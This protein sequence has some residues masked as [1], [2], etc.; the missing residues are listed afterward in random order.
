M[1]TSTVVADL[2]SGSNS[3]LSNITTISNAPQSVNNADQVQRD[4]PSQAVLQRMKEME[5]LVQDLK[6]KLQEKEEETNKKNA[7]IKKL[8]TDNEELSTERKKE[9]E[10]LYQTGIN[11]WLN[12]LQISE[13]IKEQFRKG[14]LGITKQADIKNPA[15]EVLCN[16]SKAHKENVAKINELVTLCN[17]KEK[18]IESLLQSSN[19]PTFHSNSSRMQNTFSTSTSPAIPNNSSVGAKRLRPDD[20]MDRG[21]AA[22]SSTGHHHQEGNAQEGNNDAWDH[23]AKMIYEGAKQTYY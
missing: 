2:G 8:E 5:V 15:W 19:D 16:A 11:E 12:T 4:F 9:M 20:S 21:A 17:E 22:V 23:F 7:L 6:S 13:E 14:I 10:E 1:S 3:G 18:T